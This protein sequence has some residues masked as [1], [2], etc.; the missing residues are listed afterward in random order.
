MLLKVLL[1]QGKAPTT[2][3]G[4]EWSPVA[5]DQHWA[6]NCNCN[7]EVAV[8][9]GTIEIASL[10]TVSYKKLRTGGATLP[11]YSADHPHVA[12][13]CQVHMLP[14]QQQCR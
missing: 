10:Q 1:M 3:V 9:A 6:N 5:A 4:S 8:K 14:F 12:D 11:L 2:K 13:T 7:S